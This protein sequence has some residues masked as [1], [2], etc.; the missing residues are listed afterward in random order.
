MQ[1][2]DEGEGEEGPGPDGGVAEVVG[3]EGVGHVGFGV[4][5]AESSWEVVLEFLD[6][7]VGAVVGLVRLSGCGCLFAALG[8]GACSAG[9]G[10]FSDA[11]AFEG[12]DVDG[13]AGWVGEEVGEESV[14]AEEPKSAL[15][16]G[17]GE[18]PEDLGQREHGPVDEVEGTECGVGHHEGSD[19]CECDWVD[20][21]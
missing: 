1:R 8:A 3:H 9:V 4:V 7:A 17:S 12:G 13:A 5:A 2:G 18:E 10:A 6:V 21:A 14:V 16:G 19:G 11:A 15:G 20:G